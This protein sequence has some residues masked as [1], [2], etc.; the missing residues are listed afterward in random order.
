[1]HKQRH[2]QSSTIQ[3]NTPAHL[4][5][6]IRKVTTGRNTTRRH[7]TARRANTTLTNNKQPNQARSAPS[8]TTMHHTQ[9]HQRNPQWPVTHNTSLNRRHI[10]RTT[11]PVAATAQQV[12]NNGTTR[13]LTSMPTSIQYQERTSEPTYQS[14]Q[15]LTLPSNRRALPNKQTLR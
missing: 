3:Q 15:V 7:R 11:T 1:M 9:L 4:R 5:G 13:A 6:R 10:H 8:A 14:L 2:N 12:S